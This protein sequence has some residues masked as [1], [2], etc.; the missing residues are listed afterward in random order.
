MNKRDFLTS[1]L[2]GLTGISIFSF[3]EIEKEPTKVVVPNRLK[4]GDTVGLISP[5][6]A[7]P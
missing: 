7:T 2:V 3:D 5:S 1:T 4:K 6:A